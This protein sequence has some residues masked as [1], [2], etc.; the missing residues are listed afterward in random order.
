MQKTVSQAG[1]QEQPV[2]AQPTIYCHLSCT[3]IPPSKRL[4]LILH[5]DPTQLTATRLGS[6]DSKCVLGLCFAMLGL[7]VSLPKQDV[8][9]ELCQNSNFSHHF[10]ELCSCLVKLNALLYTN[11]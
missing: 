6:G 8:L 2:S 9:K 7:L 11:K 3:Q 10:L 1:D 4:W 5:P